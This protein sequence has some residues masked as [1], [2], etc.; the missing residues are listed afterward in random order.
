MHRSDSLYVHCSL[1]CKCCE[2][3]AKNSTNKTVIYSI[4]QHND[5]PTVYHTALRMMNEELQM[6]EREREIGLNNTLG[7]CLLTQLF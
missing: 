6:K 4:I 7:K 1:G 3:K 2:N 5:L